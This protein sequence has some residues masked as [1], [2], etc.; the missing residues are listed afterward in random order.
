MSI[1]Q[2]QP[3]PQPNYSRAII[4]AAI[5]AS[6][7]YVYTQQGNQPAP[8]PVPPGPQPVVVVDAT[9]AGTQCMAAYATS[10]ASNYRDAA[11]KLRAGS[12]PDV[13]DT[14]LETFGAEARNKSFSPSMDLM[15]ATT[16][17]GQRAVLFEQ[18]AT[19]FEKAVGK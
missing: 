5:I 8:A 7:A 3:P 9:E 4:V 11:K 1:G 12:P 18:L 19:G 15:D 13:V 17:T 6:V 14:W 10:K 16:D 2:V